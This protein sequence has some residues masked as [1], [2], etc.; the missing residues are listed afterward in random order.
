[1]IETITLRPGVR[2]RCYR[3]TRFKQ[4]RLTLQLVRPMDRAEAAMNA[5]LPT[6]LLR[7]T[8]RCPDLRAITIRLDDL[9]GAAVGDLVRRIGDYQTTGFYCGFT[10]D[11]FALAGDEI[12][13]PVVEFLRELLLEPALE[14]G[15]FNAEFV[16]SEK[17]NLIADMEAQKNDKAA[18]AGS[19]LL[20]TMCRGDSFSIPRL[21]EKEQAAVITPEGLYRHY[22]KILRESPV[23][24]F[25]VGSAAPE[26]IMALLGPVFEGLDRSYVNLSPQTPFHDGGG[27]TGREE[28]DIAQSR[29]CM[30][31]VTDVTNQSPD[32]AAMQVLNTVFGAGMTSKLFMN[33][34]EKMSLCYSIGSGYYGSKGIITVSAGIDAG[35]EDVVRDQVLRQLEACKNGEISDLELTAAKEAVL[36]GLRS[37]EDSPGTIEGYFSTAALS[38]LSMDLPEYRRKVAEVTARDVAAAAGRVRC[39]SEFFLKGVAQC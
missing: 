3:D 37:V 34:R 35:K 27:A 33:V 17:K 30:G 28:M 7:G 9:Y 6:V 32:F 22:Q 23:E 29:L 38:G 13:R 1:M 12:L 15:I 4:G 25:Y 39:H 31:F 20:K 24:I 10:E 19:Q 16:R 2:L 11:R 18:Y 21:G 36:S 5:L 8:K 26:R 14:N